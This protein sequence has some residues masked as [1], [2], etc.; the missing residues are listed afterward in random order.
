MYVSVFVRAC[1]CACVC[2]IHMTYDQSAFSQI[3]VSWIVATNAIE[4]V[5]KG[6]NKSKVT[7]RSVS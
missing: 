2:D 7:G 1:V 6:A 4:T 3:T 5:N